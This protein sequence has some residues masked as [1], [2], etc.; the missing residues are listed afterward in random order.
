MLVVPKDTFDTYIL[1][2][3][4]GR[5]DWAGPN[6]PTACLFI[7]GGFLGWRGA[8]HMLV[9]SPYDPGGGIDAIDV[10]PGQRA[11]VSTYNARDVI[12]VPADSL[13]PAVRDADS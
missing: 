1:T 5:V 13:S 2:D 9:K 8:H 10:R 12:V 11:P 4:S 3:A 6:N 7:F